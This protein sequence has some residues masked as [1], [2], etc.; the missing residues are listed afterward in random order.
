MAGPE[1]RTPEAD[2]AEAGGRAGSPT[3]TDRIG[4]E[5]EPPRTGLL[6]RAADRGGAWNPEA[7]DRWRE[8]VLLRLVRMERL[9]EQSASRLPPI[10]ELERRIAEDTQ[11][12]L[13]QLAADVSRAREEMGSLAKS[14]ETVRAQALGRVDSARSETLER[15]EAARAET[16]QS[17]EAAR[18]D[19]S[20]RMDAAR[21]EVVAQV[22]A[23]RAD[24]AERVEAAGA[25]LAGEVEASFDRRL[26][27]L[28]EELPGA[29]AGR[30]AEL[31]GTWREEVRTALQEARAATVEQNRNLSTQLRAVTD[32]QASL[33]GMVEKLAKAVRE[34]RKAT[35]EALRSTMANTEA[36][37]SE[38][39]AQFTAELRGQAEGTTEDLRV[40]VGEYVSQLRLAIE[41]SLGALQASAEEATTA[42]RSDVES[43]RDEVATATQGL[44]S[45][46]ETRASALRG[47]VQ[48]VGGLL[49]SLR[50]AEGALTESVRAAVGRIEGLAEVIES[51]GHRRGFRQLVESEE[52]LR[53]QQARLVGELTAAGEGLRGHIGSTEQ[54]VDA[55]GEAARA[56]EVAQAQ[57]AE[58]VSASVEALRGSLPALADE[59]R[60]RAA[61]ELAHAVEDVRSS[62][63]EKLP[64]DE[65][66]ADVR[67]LSA[68][69]RDL[70]RATAALRAEVEGLR[71]RIE[72]WGAP[73][74]DPRLAK[75]LSEVAG[76]VERLEDRVSLQIDRLE[77]IVA[78][79]EAHLGKLVE[80]V[81]RP[82]RPRGLFGRRG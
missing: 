43:V 76:R 1:P 68:A 13:A 19:A 21:S 65:T 49:H 66:L 71:Q 78:S 62:V 14:L 69:H 35:A 81:E 24:T 59:L 60:A 44:R 10:E 63:A 75:E 27:A 74:S 30:F 46:V 28:S 15:V 31:T 22:D 50:E 29:V 55:M 11:S 20:E 12:R 57:V 34:E 48:E 47:Q 7:A 33:A 70:D 79:V 54:R 38:A 5:D 26:A 40:M 64:G 73:R 41:G 2:P 77:P 36:A 72:G 80:E 16:I 51:L 25:R 61:E 67:E 45:E 18:T 23:G 3:E 39:T 32:A 9:L 37:L 52:E 8:S 6:A 82:S 56:V 58:R 17:V 4:S 53:E 42:L